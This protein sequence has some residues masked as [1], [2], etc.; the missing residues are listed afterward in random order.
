MTANISKHVLPSSWIT[1]ATESRWTSCTRSNVITMLTGRCQGA[2]YPGVLPLTKG[3]ELFNRELTREEGSVRGTLVKGLTAEDMKYLDDFEGDE[4]IRRPIQAHPL[5]TFVNVSSQ[6][7]DDDN[8]LP[9]E[10][11][12]L[13]KNLAPAIEAQTYIYCDHTMLDAHLWS[14]EEFVKVNAWKWYGRTR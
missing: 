10:P 6:E 9:A 3:K 4:Y 5:G 14:F 11:A 12:P 7:I 13:E 2:D 1:H 8:L